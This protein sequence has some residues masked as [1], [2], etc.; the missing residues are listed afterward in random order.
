MRPNWARKPVPRWTEAGRGH[1]GGAGGSGLACCTFLHLLVKKAMQS[2]NSDVIRYLVMYI[3][4]AFQLREQ[5]L[6]E[7]KL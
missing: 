7:K 2:K 5:K 4:Y 3:Y 1:A 6:E